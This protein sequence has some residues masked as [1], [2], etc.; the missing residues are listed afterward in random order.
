VTA[1]S[2]RTWLPASILEGDSLA[3]PG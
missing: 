3:H 1:A 2:E